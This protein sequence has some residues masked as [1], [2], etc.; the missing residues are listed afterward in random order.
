[1]LDTRQ[2]KLPI[3]TSSITSK[4]SITGNAAT[5]L[6]DMSARLNTTPVGLPSKSWQHRG[7]AWYSKNRGK[8]KLDTGL[9]TVEQCM[10]KLLDSVLPRLRKGHGKGR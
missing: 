5:P 1:M 6:W 10:S 8:L 2:E 4:D 7:Y 9:L 3:G